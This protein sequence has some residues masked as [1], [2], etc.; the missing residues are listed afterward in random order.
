[1]ISNLD[2]KVTQAIIDIHVSK[3]E[4]TKL[5]KLIQWKNFKK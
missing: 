4:N 5:N 2:K 3:I 1:M